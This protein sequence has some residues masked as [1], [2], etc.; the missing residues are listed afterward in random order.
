MA[1]FR[2]HVLLPYVPVL[3]VGLHRHK[4]CSVVLGRFDRKRDLWEASVVTW[5]LR[6]VFMFHWKMVQMFLSQRLCNETKNCLY[7]TVSERVKGWD[8]FRDRR[9]R[10]E[11]GV[12]G[13]GGKVWVNIQ[14]FKY[15]CGLNDC[16]ILDIPICSTF[17]FFVS[18]E[19]GNLLVILCVLAQGLLYGCLFLLQV[20]LLF[21]TTLQFCSFK[22]LGWHTGAKTAGFY[23]E[24]FNALLARK[25]LKGRWRMFRKQK[26]FA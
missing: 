10:G 15:A 25:E 9:D 1:L 19:V 24:L 13:G 3:T 14:E 4:C 6:F 8:L 7:V 17:A 16:H 26:Q 12:V 18:N 23:N 21:C 20:I 2:L 11:M 22:A 5:W